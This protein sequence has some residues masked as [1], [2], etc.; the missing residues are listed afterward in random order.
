[1]LLSVN[2]VATVTL[3]QNEQTHN[4]GKQKKKIKFFMIFEDAL[5]RGNLV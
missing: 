5:T 2:E 1:M 4:F 3:L